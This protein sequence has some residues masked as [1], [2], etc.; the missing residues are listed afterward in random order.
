MRQV[1]VFWSEKDVNQFLGEP[2]SG[3]RI[4]QITPVSVNGMLGFMVEFIVNDKDV[5]IGIASRKP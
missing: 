4:E 2:T 1:K 3:R 5:Q